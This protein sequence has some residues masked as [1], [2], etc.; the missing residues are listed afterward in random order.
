[1]WDHGPSKLWQPFQ[2]LWP[3]GCVGHFQVCARRPWALATLHWAAHRSPRGGGWSSCLLFTATRIGGVSSWFLSLHLI[4][5]WVRS[6][7]LPWHRNQLRLRLSQTWK[8]VLVTNWDRFLDTIAW[9]L[10]LSESAFC[11][12]LFPGCGWH[13]SFTESARFSYCATGVERKRGVGNFGSRPS[14]KQAETTLFKTSWCRFAV[15]IMSMKK[16]KLGSESAR[17]VA[18]F[19]CWAPWSK[20]AWR[21]LNLMSLLF[22]PQQDE[23]CRC[24]HSWFAFCAS[25]QQGDLLPVSA[26]RTQKAPFG[27]NRSMSK[28][29]ETCPLIAWTSS[30]L[31]ELLEV[32]RDSKQFKTSTCFFLQNGM[33]RLWISLS[34]T[35]QCHWSER[36]KP[37]RTNKCQFC[38]PVSSFR[39]KMVQEPEPVGCWCCYFWVTLCINNVAQFPFPNIF[40]EYIPPQKLRPVEF[41]PTAQPSSSKETKMRATGIAH[42][43]FLR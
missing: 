18:A 43:K 26:L 37:V 39:A 4:T 17:E 9:S 3:Y 19:S 41:L 14:G 10:L 31:C 27:C 5:R 15:T 33:R 30:G 22:F 34:T 1:M 32:M 20:A 24:G 40:D 21:N 28:S 6:F 38:Y 42:D 12:F 16:Q 11:I 7:T 23:L 35:S 8:D 13:A 25:L 2:P 36:H 29:H